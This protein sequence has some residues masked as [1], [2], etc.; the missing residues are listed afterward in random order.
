MVGVLDLTDWLEK[1]R[2]GYHKHDG[3]PEHPVRVKHHAE[4]FTGQTDKPDQ[5]SSDISSEKTITNIVGDIHSLMIPALQD[6][7]EQ[8]EIVGDSPEELLRTWNTDIYSDDDESFFDE[9]ISPSDISSEINKLN[10]IST[11]GDVLDKVLSDEDFNTLLQGLENALPSPKRAVLEKE[12]DR[13]RKILDAPPSKQDQQ[14]SI[15]GL[16]EDETNALL[17]AKRETMNAYDSILEEL[18]ELDDEYR[19]IL[20][21]LI[22]TRPITSILDNIDTFV[23]SNK[24][25]IHDAIYDLMEVDPTADFIMDMATNEDLDFDKRS[26]AI[27][28]LDGKRFHELITELTGSEHY[29]LRE[30]VK[31]GLISSEFFDS[32]YY[33]NLPMTNYENKVAKLEKLHDTFGRDAVNHFIEHNEF[34]ED[35]V[36]DTTYTFNV[37][38]TDPGKEAKDAFIS[39]YNNTS[40]GHIHRVSMNEW[41]T[42]SSSDWG[43]LLKESI[44]RQLDGDVLHHS[45]PT[46]G[47]LQ[48]MY[49]SKP[50]RLM[51]FTESKESFDGF[52]SS[53]IKYKTNQELLDTYVL[54]HKNAIRKVLDYVYKD[55][56][57]IPVY[58][59]TN[60]EE[61]EELT[62]L[63][64][65]KEDD[66]NP[67]DVKG[68]PVSSYTLDSKVAHKFADRGDSGWVI[69]S[70]VHKD[71]IWSNFWS[72]SYQGNEREFLVINKERESVGIL[73]NTLKATEGSPLASDYNSYG[74]KQESVY[75]L[76]D[77]QT[78]DILDLSL[79][80]QSAYKI[81]DPTVLHSVNDHMNHYTSLNNYLLEQVQ[82]N[83]M[84]AY[85]A[86]E[87]WK[88]G[89]QNAGWKKNSK[90]Q[91]DPDFLDL[92]DL[93][94]KLTR[95]F[96][97][98]AGDEQNI[99]KSQWISKQSSRTMLVPYRT[100]VNR[101]GKTPYFATRWKKVTVPQ[102]TGT[103]YSV[104]PIDEYTGDIKNIYS[105]W[106]GYVG[107]REEGRHD[108]FLPIIA[109]QEILYKGYDGLLAIFNNRIVG[110]VSIHIN[111]ADEARLS[112]LS[113]SPFD[114]IQGTE[115]RIEDML[116]RGV[117]IYVQNKGLDYVGINE[118]YIEH[119]HTEMDEED[120][121]I[122]KAR[123]QLI[124]VKVPITLPS[125]KKTEGIRWKKGRSDPKAFAV[126][127]DVFEAVKD[128]P[129]VK[130][131]LEMVA[132]KVPAT[133]QRETLELDM[134]PENNVI[135]R[136][137]NAQGKWSYIRSTEKD[138]ETN[139]AKHTKVAKF[140]KALP[141]IRKDI[142]R[143]MKKG[144]EEALI[145]HLIDVAGL[146]IG[147][148]PNNGSAFDRTQPKDTDGNFP[149]VP[150]YAA[151]QLLG[152][153]VSIDGTKVRLQYPA[154][155][156]VPI[157]KTIDNAQLA[158]FFSDKKK[159]SGDEDKLF[160]PT[161]SKVRSYL[162]KL[163]GGNDFKIHNFRHYHAT[164][165]VIDELK[166]YPIP[167]VDSSEISKAVR[168]AEIKQFKEGGR[169]K[170]SQSDRKAVVAD[171]VAKQ[172]RKHQLVVSKVSADF[173]AHTPTVSLSD[174]VLPSVWNAWEQEQDKLVRN[175]ISTP[176]PE[177][178]KV[179]KI[180]RVKKQD[181]DDYQTW[182][183]MDDFFERN[184]YDEEST[185]DDNDDIFIEDI[186]ERE[187]EEASEE[188]WQY[189]I[190]LSKSTASIAE[191]KRRGLVPQSGNWSKPKRWV[192]P[193]NGGEDSSKLTK[194]PED[195][196]KYFEKV[197]DTILVDIDK[198]VP[199][200][201]R[202][203]GII[204]AN[205][206]MQ[207]LLSRRKPLDLKDNG[208][209]TYSILDGNSTYANA[210]HSEWKELPG[211]VVE[212]PRKKAS[213]AS[214][215]KLNPHYDVVFELASQA[216]PFI[217]SEDFEISDL[218]DVYSIGLE[219]YSTEITQVMHYSAKPLAN[220]NI[221]SW[222]S[223]MGI[224]V[225]IDINDSS[226]QKIGS[227]FRTFSRK[228][229][230]L[231][232]RHQNFSLDTPFQGKG[233]ATDIIEHA[234]N[235]YEKLGVNE[236]TLH[237]N[238]RIGGYTWAVQGYDFI[239]DRWKDRIQNLFKKSVT[240]LHEK[241]K[242]SGDLEPLLETIDSFN[243]SWEF[244]SWNP[245][246]YTSKKGY[247][248]GKMILIGTS[249][250]ASKSLDKKSIGYQIGKA[251][252]ALKRQ[253][254]EQTS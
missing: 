251:Y 177:P 42:S 121:E 37:M 232:V 127:D 84:P 217:F 56:D 15:A 231:S 31:S 22:G 125:G 252:F 218:Q 89:I 26:K 101:P 146:R 166:E 208:D 57:Y 120:I 158:K 154:K 94:K 47:R 36:F 88:N 24:W 97:T 159:T 230:I 102:R 99:Q 29:D 228:E 64:E 85:K 128:N 52:K 93:I 165:L 54:S 139:E 214:K 90:L 58:R 151:R 227:M 50:Q 107:D 130:E 51:D 32:L 229:G 21:V 137:I 186:E 211:V 108:L 222:N 239:N 104:V 246:G 167:T 39:L 156:N 136:A 245:S 250:E 122:E 174:Y 155:D 183:D 113:A 132:K 240:K 62:S 202:P 169:K 48:E 179:R 149:R 200:R 43:G 14:D 126:F 193:K 184:I 197:P 192:L 224:K 180:T 66:W 61:I 242:I 171:Y 59:G 12:R 10:T 216:L 118:E 194:L 115:N 248:L 124:P 20:E 53:P 67:V 190:E 198:L 100:M 223:K 83:G 178:K 72:H 234:E 238:D 4:Y 157:D 74:F 247:S 2:R 129:D 17:V 23:N 249:W 55:Q 173:L 103:A 77:E 152:K 235:Q 16:S 170:L 68:N 196:W 49:L 147:Y 141:Q 70:L 117:E 34:P 13:L 11:F 18:L 244:A 28:S 19:F 213:I 191:A 215:N 79:D 30:G 163:G 46:I 203:E 116:R 73:S 142:E 81:D 27:L 25:Y 188:G 114:I 254:N 133:W 86:L 243:H 236:I 140:T 205:K 91:N 162:Q 201:A 44:G 63:E 131:Y 87:L 5:A 106:K 40:F 105:S 237:A 82:N 212:K 123:G 80:V 144:D 253:K 172:F 220:P 76:S 233:I 8:G 110:V 221:P 35:V 1:Q 96:E 98:E 6:A 38:K 187:A 71:D 134:N 164:R 175:H 226:G 206:R 3:F 60:R 135:A 150:T 207:Q 111:Q 41:E 148:E 143:G 195:T 119:E 219:D 7:I 45:G 181:S 33:L 145:L 138:S 189:P 199:T 168:R 225:F 95:N 65:Y 185:L 78:S 176:E 210:L 69:S 182:E 209:G 160:E 112:I 153:H 75:S 161:A 9:W 109:L 204:E 241:G 92:P